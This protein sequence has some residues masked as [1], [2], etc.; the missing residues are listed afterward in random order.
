MYRETAMQLDPL[1]LEE[2]GIRLKKREFDEVTSSHT[3]A[4]YTVCCDSLD[5]NNASILIPY[6]LFILCNYLFLF[7]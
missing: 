7:V 6:I 2:I 5:G 1:Y 4:A 3:R